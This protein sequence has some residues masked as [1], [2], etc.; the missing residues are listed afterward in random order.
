M[1]V[2]GVHSLLSIHTMEGE[3]VAV[4]FPDEEDEDTAKALSLHAWS[5]IVQWILAS[6]TEMFNVL[7]AKH[8]GMSK[9][10]VGIEIKKL[11]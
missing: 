7:Y 4:N 10:N 8:M 6:N 2:E 5:P 3:D 1:L 11:I 9:L